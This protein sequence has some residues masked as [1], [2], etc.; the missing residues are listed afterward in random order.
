MSRLIAKTLIPHWRFFL[1]RFNEPVLRTTAPNL[2]C[3]SRRPYSAKPHVIEIDLESSSSSA[4]SRAEAE[5]AVLKKLNEFVRRIVVQNSTPDWLPFAPG[6]SFWVPPHQNTA[7]KIANLVDRVTNPLTEEEAFSLFSPSGSPASS[8]F[9][10]PLDDGYSST[11]EVEGSME[12][13]IPGIE[14][15]EVK[16]AHFPDPFYSFKRGGDDEE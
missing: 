2:V 6:S 13:N 11:Q 12:L 16:L 1:R 7:V 10:P 14:M 3:F 15:L 8:F 9:I 4:T 5:A